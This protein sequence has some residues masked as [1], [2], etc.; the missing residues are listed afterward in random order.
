[1]A[2]TSKIKDGN[3]DHPLLAARMKAQLLTCHE[4]STVQ[5]LVQKM[6]ALQAQHLEMT[7]WAIGK[8]L[9]LC[10]RGEAVTAS[11]VQKALGKGHIVRTHALR[12]TWQLLSG[13]DLLWILQ[14]TGP[15]IK[16]TLF[17]RDKH[18][19]IEEKEYVRSDKAIYRILEKH[20][21]LSRQELSTALTQ[22]GFAM[23]EYRSN[24]YIMHAELQGIICSGPVSN[25]KHTYALLEKVL[26]KN[27]K[28]AEKLKNTLKDQA[29]VQQLAS[30]YFSTRGPASLQ[31]FA[32]WSGLGITQIKKAI[33]ALGD[34]IMLAED[35]FSKEQQTAGTAYYQMA[36]NISA[37]RPGLAALNSEGLDAKLQFLAAFDEYLISY[38]DRTAML[39][40]AY[41]KQ[42]ITVNGLFRPAVV[43]K[44]QVI[45][46]WQVEKQIHKGAKTGLKIKLLPFVALNTAAQKQILKLAEPE[47]LAY[48]RFRQLPLEALGMG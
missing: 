7:Q 17:S 46:G 19:G 39:P 12:P 8:R 10:S 48:A 25:D 30:R 24:H 33:A 2:T 20:P 36:S 21:H 40:A 32:W 26:G 47:A 45:A 15:A 27:Y 16:K 9:S 1:M 14:L 42:I 4:V 38:K 37:A 11:D 34:K 3:K 29:G 5:T 6:G 35:P 31:D 18:L 44:G 22:L 23:D 28:K 41:N 13:E 43:E